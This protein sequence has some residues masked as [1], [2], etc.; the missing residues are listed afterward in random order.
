MSIAGLV[1]AAGAGSRYGGPKVLARDGDGTPWIA[2]AVTALRHGGCSAVLVAIGADRDAARELLSDIVGVDRIV[3]VDGWT[4]GLSAS[5][6]AGLAALQDDAE[7]DS[8]VFVPVDV[9]SL[10]AAMVRRVIDEARS[11]NVRESGADSRTFRL[12]SASLAQAMF[13]GRPGHPVLIGRDHWAPLRASVSG[14]SGARAY[15]V[16]HGVD[17]IDCSDLGSGEDTDTRRP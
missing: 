13:D 15:L 9:P 6:I 17:E 14:D 12:L 8:V 10:S 3:D 5:I 2:R 7:V 1:L 11:P 4:D 16:A